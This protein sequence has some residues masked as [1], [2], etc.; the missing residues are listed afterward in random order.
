MNENGLWYVYK[1][2][3]RTFGT[4]YDF[5]NVNSG[6]HPENVLTFNVSLPEIKYNFER[7]SQFFIDLKSRLEAT[8]GVQSASSIYPLPLNGD[9][10]VISFEIEGRPMS[11]KDQPIAEFFTTGVGYFRAM[12]I[13]IIKGRD[14]D[15]RDKH[16]STPVIIVSETFARQ[17]FPNE[18]PIGKRIHP[19]I[20]SIDGEHSAMREI[21]GV[22]GDVRNQNL[23][24]ASKPA[25]Y[26][27][28]TQ[29]PFSQMVAVVKTTGEPHG[30]ADPFL[31]DGARVR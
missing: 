8:P 31:R 5:R 30:M 29:V 28:Q 14:F 19:G 7:Q 17:I 13:P 27:P 9:R 16:G 18:D 1:W 23:S 6:L 21:I 20:S 3:D 26:V 22:V 12:G 11:P 15:D 10:F 24:T 4:Y 25:Y 2:T